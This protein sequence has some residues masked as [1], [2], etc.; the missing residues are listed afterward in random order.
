MNAVIPVNILDR[1][2]SRVQA[3]RDDP[4][5]IF[6]DEAKESGIGKSA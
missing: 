5:D 3:H 1:S 2:R 6:Q 4:Q